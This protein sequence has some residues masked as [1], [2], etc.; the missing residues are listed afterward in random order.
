MLF[1]VVVV[2]GWT[3]YYVRTN[4]PHFTHTTSTPHRMHALAVVDNLSIYST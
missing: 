4:S 2:S 1:H 3:T